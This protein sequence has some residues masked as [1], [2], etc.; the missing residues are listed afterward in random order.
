MLPF[1]ISL[2]LWDNFF[3]MVNFSLLYQGL[4]LIIVNILSLFYILTDPNYNLIFIRNLS[5]L[6]K[7]QDCLFLAQMRFHVWYHMPHHLQILLWPCFGTFSVLFFFFS[8]LVLCYISINFIVILFSFSCL[9]TLEHIS[10]LRASSYGT[11]GS[12]DC[13]PFCWWWLLAIKESSLGKF[14]LPLSSKF[15]RFQCLWN[16]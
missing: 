2:I 11:S 10:C 4:I 8:S 3:W 14:V 16:F 13:F 7:L 15:P 9:K 6:C 1:V 5:S 12:P